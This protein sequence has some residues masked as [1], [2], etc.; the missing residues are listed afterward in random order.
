MIS[1]PSPTGVSPPGLPSLRL[2][3]H[4]YTNR[5]TEECGNESGGRWRATLQNHKVNLGKGDKQRR[6]G[7][8]MLNKQ[9][10]HHWI[11]YTYIQLTQQIRD[12]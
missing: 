10:T 4:R 9:Q 12:F 8:K 3:T 5:Q 1:S 6:E 11:N 2:S 7:K